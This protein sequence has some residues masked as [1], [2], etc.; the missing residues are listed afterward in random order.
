MA[1]PAC[2]TELG[3]VWIDVARKVLSHVDVADI[4]GLDVVSI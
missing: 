1:P 4:P 2:K 3:S